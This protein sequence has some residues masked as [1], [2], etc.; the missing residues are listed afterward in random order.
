MSLLYKIK[1]DLKTAMLGKKTEVGDTIRIIM[2]ES[3]SITVPITQNP[4]P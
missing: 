4:L 3:P 1:A 2:G